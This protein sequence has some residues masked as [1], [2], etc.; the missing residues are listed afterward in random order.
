MNG[1]TSEIEDMHRGG[2]NIQ[3]A[4]AMKQNRVALKTLKQRQAAK[5]RR[6]ARQMIKMTD[7]LPQEV[8]SSGFHYDKESSQEVIEESRELGNQSDD[9]MENHEI[10]YRPQPLQHQG[11]PHLQHTNPV[12]K[13]H[14]L[15]YRVVAN[16]R[17]GGKPVIQ[18]KGLAL[19]YDNTQSPFVSATYLDNGTVAEGVLNAASRQPSQLISLSPLAPRQ[20]PRKKVMRKRTAKRPAPQK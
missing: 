5:A 3:I 20:K 14:S 17:P 13:Q 11:L 10:T 19:N 1:Y 7:T 18:V 2:A 4:G 9:E 12:V 16:K 8:Q 15:K 6:A